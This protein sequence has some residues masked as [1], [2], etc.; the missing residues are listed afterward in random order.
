MSTLQKTFSKVFI[1]ELP[2]MKVASYRTVSFSPERDAINYMK[3][4]I[5]KGKLNF[6]NLRKFG[7]IVP[8]SETQQNLGLRGY[9][10]WVCLPDDINNLFGLTIMY[11]PVSNYAVLRIKDPF[12][13]PFDIISNGWLELHDWIK[14]SGFKT[15][16]HNPNK[17]MLEELIEID[18]VTYMDLF[19]PVCIYE[20]V[21]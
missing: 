3:E 6:N 11:M 21:N 16:L 4:V 5:K 2:S 8:V 13:R 15:A 20:Y 19:Y 18:G 1:K 10:Y 7:V 12:K 9:E 14:A 17:Y